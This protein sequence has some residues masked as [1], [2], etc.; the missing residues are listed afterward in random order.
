MTDN[1]RNKD[2]SKL[3]DVL[4][5]FKVDEDKYISYEF[6]KYGYEDTELVYRLKKKGYRFVFSPKATNIHMHVISPTEQEKKIRSESQ[7]NRRLPELEQNQ[8]CVGRAGRRE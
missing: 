3:G 5:R 6:Q 1:K 7:G 2:F 8:R 4:K